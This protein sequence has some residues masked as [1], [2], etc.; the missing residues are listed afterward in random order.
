MGALRV[1]HPVPRAR[2]RRPVVHAF[3]LRRGDVDVTTGL[4]HFKVKGS[5]FLRSQKGARALLP[6]GE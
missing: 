3:G 2:P 6:A 4:A 5:L 1:G